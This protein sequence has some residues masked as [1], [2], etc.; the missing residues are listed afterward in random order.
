MKRSWWKALGGFV[1]AVAAAAVV[2]GV[3]TTRNQDWYRSLRKPPF[4]PPDWL[5]GPAWTTLYAL[6][7]TSA[8]RVW[9][10]PPSP[11]RSRALGLWGAQLALNAAWSPLFFGAHR[12]R[13][14]LVDLALLVVGICAYAN[15]A[16]KVDAP[17]AWMMAPYGAWCAFAGLLNEEIVRLN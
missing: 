6:M 16:R 3:A 17:A 9:R 12:P 10:A 11:E 8:Y 2:G 5:F 7:A 1:G 13:A 4:N 14:A 15:E